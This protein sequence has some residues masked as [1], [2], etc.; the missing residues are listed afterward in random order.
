MADP[1]AIAQA[2]A[3]VRAAR[4]ALYALAQQRRDLLLRDR[5][6][7]ALL[8]GIVAARA[9]L[10]AAHHSLHDARTA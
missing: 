9:A 8:A 2:R 7:G 5:D 6:V 1:L 4:H 10:R 3:N